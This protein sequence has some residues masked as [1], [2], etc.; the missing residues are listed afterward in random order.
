MCP[1]GARASSHRRWLRSA[2]VGLALASSLAGVSAGSADGAPCPLKSYTTDG[3][4]TSG[5]CRGG[6]CCGPKG[7]SG[8]CT[9]CDSAGDCSVCSSGHTLTGSQCFCTGSTCCNVAIPKLALT[10]TKIT[11]SVCNKGSCFFCIYTPLLKV[12]K[13]ICEVILVSKYN[14][15]FLHF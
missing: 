10:T 3:G 4:C 6:N 9:D 1:R 5:V 12:L 7:R 11:S 8:G 14:Q 13:S 2:M 15:G